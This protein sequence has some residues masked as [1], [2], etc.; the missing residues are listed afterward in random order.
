MAITASYETLLRQAPMTAK[1]Y[2]LA[3]VAN[4]NEQFGDGYA[5]QHPELV[6]AFMQVC[7]S[8][9]NNSAVIIAI[10][11]AAELISESL[12]EDLFKKKKSFIKHKPPKLM[13]KIALI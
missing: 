2:M 3:A 8:D 11:E 4:I 9:Y 12:T 10:Q 13:K 7:A 1:E 5:R 6:A